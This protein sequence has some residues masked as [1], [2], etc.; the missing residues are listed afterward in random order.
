MAKRP[1]HTPTPEQRRLHA[2]KVY[3]RKRTY[4]ATATELG[5]SKKRAHELVKAGLAIEL[6]EARKR[7]EGDTTT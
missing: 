6:A 7:D 1:T 2:V 5:I 4:A 3:R